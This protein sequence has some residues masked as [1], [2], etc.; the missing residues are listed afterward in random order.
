M[1]LCNVANS[2]EISLLLLGTPPTA[3]IVWFLPWLC[4]SW[5]S[6][7]YRGE[8][9][10][11]WNKVDIL[12]LLPLFH[13]HLGVVKFVNELKLTKP[14]I[15]YLHKKHM[16]VYNLWQACDVGKL[17]TEKMCIEVD[18]SI[19]KVVW[20]SHELCK[21]KQTNRS[22][23]QNCLYAKW[24]TTSLGVKSGWHGP[25]SEECDEN[26]GCNSLLALVEKALE[27]DDLLTKSK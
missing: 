24:T 9:S 5:T 21:I 11:K 6:S 4:A 13:F 7:V 8:D 16:E 26:S 2:F 27:W 14:C 17:L 23:K 10:R 15:V 20:E 1:Q 22:G 18:V 3:V 19:R 12:Y 25:S